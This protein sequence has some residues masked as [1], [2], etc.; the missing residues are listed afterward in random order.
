[1]REDCMV[2]NV[3][4]KLTTFHPWSMTMSNADNKSIMDRCYE[5]IMDRC[6]ECTSVL[7]LCYQNSM[8]WWY[9]WIKSSIIGKCSPLF[10][11]QICLSMSV[12]V[13]VLFWVSLCCYVSF[14]IHYS[15]NPCNKRKKKNLENNIHLTVLTLTEASIYKGRQTE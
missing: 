4:L 9:R 15:P 3:Q 12:C 5:C 14:T 7:R 10:F 2:L 13:C 6:Y 1:M 8:E 11:S